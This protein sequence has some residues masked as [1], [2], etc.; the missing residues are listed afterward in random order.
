VQRLRYALFDVLDVAEAIRGLTEAGHTASARGV[1]ATAPPVPVEGP[2]PR[3]S[4]KFLARA[5]AFLAAVEI[6]LPQRLMRETGYHLQLSLI[7]LVQRVEYIGSGDVHTLAQLR[8]L[9]DDFFIYW[10]EA[11]DSETR[12]FWEQ[13]QA[14]G[15]PYQRVDHLG[16]ILTRGRIASRTEYEF[17]VDSVVIAEQDGRLTS[18]EASR[19]AELI[20]AYE[21]GRRRR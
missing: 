7:G 11:P 8:Y 13:V 5:D 12:A 6:A 9:E 15:L 1:A 14:Q 20:G 2:A 17:A 3:G 16:K 19:L 4:A 10:N 21:Q 18:A